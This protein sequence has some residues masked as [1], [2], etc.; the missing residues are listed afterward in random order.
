[1]SGVLTVSE[2]D[3]EGLPLLHRGKVRD[4]YQVG[5]NQLLLVATDRLSAF[6]CIL[7]TPIK[8]KGAVL[9]ALSEFWFDRLKNVTENHLITA[10]FDEMPKVIRRNENLRNR[11]MLV[12][13]TK[14]FP[15]ECV[16]RGYLEGSGWKDY[17]ATGKVCGYDLPEN[18]KQCDKLPEPLFTPS[19]KAATGHDENISFEE[20]EKIVGA[21]TAAELRLR[22]LKI[23]DDA[24]RYAL[25]R[26]IIIA[27]T[28]F[29]FG[30]DENGNIL[31]IDEVLTPDS[32]RF[33]SAETYSPGKPQPSFDKQFVREYLETLDW[34]KQPPAP[35]LPA[36][37]AEATTQRYLKA[38]ELLT[39]KK[40]ITENYG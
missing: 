37:I 2:T 13:K 32:S 21:E 23:Y 24:S 19:T 29:E 26:G 35:E 28:K 18:L 39:G 20:A 11:S 34:N 8:Y 25:T 40:L 10:N 14:V 15:V 4:V 16:V 6:D 36:E 12:K 7:P 17:Q 27:D 3:V 31:L 30:A 22:A 5:E 9:T 1:M 38:Y 33:W